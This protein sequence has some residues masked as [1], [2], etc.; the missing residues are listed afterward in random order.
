M[1]VWCVLES[2][3]L[4]FGREGQKYFFSLALNNDKKT[5]MKTVEN[6]HIYR[7]K[8]RFGPVVF[9]EVFHKEGALLR[10]QFLFFFDIHYPSL[11]KLN[12]VS[13][14][15]CKKKRCSKKR[16]W[17]RSGAWGVGNCL[18]EWARGRGIKKIANSRGCARGRHGYKSNWTMHNP[19][20]FPL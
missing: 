14:C 2:W 3:I 12:N 6:E 13:L 8:E 19:L 1:W 17:G 15:Y 4:L 10:V 7:E 20:I 9:F 18:F 11:S 5:Y 16:I